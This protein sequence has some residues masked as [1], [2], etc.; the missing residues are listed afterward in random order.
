MK[1][2]LVTIL[3]LTLVFVGCNTET[4]VEEDKF[5]DYK[6]VS[7][8]PSITENII[9]IGMEDTLVAVD[10]YSI[11]DETSDLMMIDAYAINVEEILMLEPTHILISDYNYA[12]DKQSDYKVFEDA[13]IKVIPIKGAYSIDDIYEGIIEI[14]VA[15]DNEEAGQKLVE[16]TKEKVEEI[17][18][19]YADYE[20]KT[21]YM[22]IAPAPDIY[23][24]AKGSFTNEMIELVGGKNIFDDVED[25]YFTPS[26]ENIIQKNPE[27]IITNVSYI[28]DPIGEI[29]KRD[30]F[31][32]ITAVKN[33]AVYQ[34]DTDS[35]SRPSCGFLKGLEELAQAIHNEN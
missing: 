3:A 24:A 11:F 30:G 20:V 7:L 9:G 5:E 25:D 4:K 16:E 2:I 34:V 29:L 28:E 17:K 23:S 22:E 32:E 15:L 14:A 10:T 26:V 8:S 27:V 21:V 13:D 31:N 35:T 6:V 33:N 19:E 18:N 12:G 1:K